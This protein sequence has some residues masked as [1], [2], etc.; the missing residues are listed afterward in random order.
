MRSILVSIDNDD[1]YEK[2]SSPYTEVEVKAYFAAKIEKII[3]RLEEMKETHPGIREELQSVLNGLN[4]E[5]NAIKEKGLMEAPKNTF[6]HQEQTIGSSTFSQQQ[7]QKKVT[8]EVFVE[9]MRGERKWRSIA[10]ADRWYKK[11]NGG[12]LESN[13]QL[14]MDLLAKMPDDVKSLITF[15]D[16]IY[17][18]NEFCNVVREEA[19]EKQ[20]LGHEYQ[21]MGYQII[22]TQR[23]D[24]SLT[25]TLIAPHEVEYFVESLRENKRLGEGPRQ[26]LVTPAGKLIREGA[27]PFSNISNFNGSEFNR[28]INQI[29]L[30]NGNLSSIIIHE[31]DPWLRSQDPNNVINFVIKQLLPSHGDIAR[32]IPALEKRLQ[33]S[34]V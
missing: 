22:V 31:P 11:A 7:Q 4:N 25:Y 27:Y 15:D 6:V 3:G 19:E 18:S 24:G 28:A 12:D 16:N 33:T 26:W 5:L 1:P 9:S 13:R 29:Q 30:F 10:Y 34:S 2:F 32:H 17:V 8:K 21:R 14:I 23:D 20:V